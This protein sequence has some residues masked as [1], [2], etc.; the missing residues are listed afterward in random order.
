MAKLSTPIGR[1]TILCI[2][3]NGKDHVALR[4]IIS[5]HTRWKLFTASDLTSAIDLLGQHEIAV[6]VCEQDLTP[7]TCWKDVLEL[8]GTFPNSPSLIVSSRFA[9]EHLWAEALN[10]GAWDVLATP[11][12]KTEVI[13]SVISAWRRWHDQIEIGRVTAGQIQS[14]S[15]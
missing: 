13:R 9:D 14:A 4:S 15:G 6:L 8:I 12:N 1:L 10:L 2:S 5:H 7:G 3:P 11:F